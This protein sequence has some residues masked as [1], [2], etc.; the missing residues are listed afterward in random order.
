M[1]PPIS[2]SRIRC[3]QCG[4]VHILNGYV[5][6]GKSAKC[7]KCKQR[8]VI[9]AENILVEGDSIPKTQVITEL[10]NIIGPLPV[11]LAKEPLSKS[12]CK[13]TETCAGPIGVVISFLITTTSGSWEADNAYFFTLFCGLCIGVGTITFMQRGNKRKTIWFALSLLLVVGIYINAIRGSTKVRHWKNDRSTADYSDTYDRWSGQHTHRNV[14][15]RDPSGKT[16]GRSDGPMAGTG[17]PHGIWD[18]LWFE[19]LR[20]DKK[21][22][23]YGEVVTEGEWHLRNKMAPQR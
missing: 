18:E 16:L 8:F 5:P 6:L 13:T 17:K 2:V 9:Y 14:W 15:H 10:R 22:Y 20:M 21:F 1:N 11:A 3:E 12:M 19:P 4:H 23:W 7:G